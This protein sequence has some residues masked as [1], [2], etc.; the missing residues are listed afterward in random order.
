MEHARVRD[1]VDRAWA[2]HVIPSLSE[3]VEIPAVSPAYDPSWRAGGQLHAAVD[4]VRRW[5]ESSGLPGVACQVV[6][7]DGRTPLLLV[8]VPAT[9]GSASSGTVVFYGHLDKQPALGEWSPGLGPWQAVRR[10]DRLYGRGSVDDGYAAY[11]AVTA[12]GAV[13]AAGGEH[14]RAVVL[15]ETGEESG[16]PDLPV[17][18]EHLSDRLG[19]VTLV[20]CLD[21]GGDD[22]ERLWLTSSL[23][24]AVQATVTV[25][26]LDTPVHSGLG[27]G[28]VPNPFLVMRGLLD[29][30]EDPATGEVRVPEMHAPLPDGLREEVEELVALDPGRVTRRFPL[31][32]GVV[33]LV[34]DDVELIVNNTWRP[35]LSV[36]G[37]AGLPEASSAGAVLLDAVSLRLSFRLPPPVDAETARAALEKVV[38]TDVPYGARVEVTDAMTINGW[39]APAVAPW[40]SAALV[41]V[42]EQVYGEPCR[43][44]GLGGG[45]PFME[46]LGRRYP[47]AQFVVTGALGPDSNLHVPDEWLNI[48]FARQLTESIAHIVDAHSAGR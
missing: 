46:T 48:P 11:A 20:V 13:R 6:E 17:Y 36:I 43:S 24:G 31:V 41:D 45:I 5:V 8:E 39:H 18:L 10:G 47:D 7:L 15:L 32:E 30:L 27:G 28:I 26:V 40:L 16:S 22:Y 23:R 4:H 14:A 38:T 42:A 12:L 21:S 1:A 25:R 37:A 34:A 19:D 9:A 35:A 44:A 3:L 33:P 29:R 2:D